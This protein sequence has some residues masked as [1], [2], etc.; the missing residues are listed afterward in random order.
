[1]FV[2]VTYKNCQKNKENSI[3]KQYNLRTVVIIYWK[4]EKEHTGM[5]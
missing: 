4:Q 1:M 3:D 2:K 5:Q